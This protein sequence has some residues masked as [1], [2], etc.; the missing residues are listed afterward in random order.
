MCEMAPLD[1]DD[2]CYAIFHC[3][4]YLDYDTHIESEFY[5]SKFS[6]NLLTYAAIG[7]VPRIP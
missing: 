7:L 3:G 4:Y 5:T 6:H 2:P 1:P